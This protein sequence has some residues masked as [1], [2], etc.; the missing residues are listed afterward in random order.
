[1]FGLLRRAL[2]WY[3]A[4]LA[5]ARIGLFCCGLLV[6]AAN[7]LA[8]RYLPQR[9]DATADRRY[10]PSPNARQ[11]LA[12]ID[13]PIVLRLYY[14]PALGKAKPAYGVY[15]RR[16]RI[17]LD[18]FVAAARGRLQLRV[19]DVE[20]RS[21]AAQQAAGF[22]LESVPLGRNGGRGYFGLAGTNSTD[23]RAVIT[24]FDPAR[25][26]L[27]DDELAGLLHALAIPNAIGAVAGAEFQ[28]D[29]RDISA[30]AREAPAGL[31]QRP[32]TRRLTTRLQ[33]PIA[34]ADIALMP[35]LVAAVAVNIR[36]RRRLGRG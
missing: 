34:A 13:E 24:L 1:V 15:E 29:H 8:Q 6:V 19:R 28:P 16:V 25:A 7:I 20:P 21:A 10:T 2:G 18:Q 14:S 36:R 11:V 27:L 22:G 17:L 3:G 30:R 23:D 35:L 4:P 32:V 12:Q 26:A 9:F 31:A 33:A 5:R